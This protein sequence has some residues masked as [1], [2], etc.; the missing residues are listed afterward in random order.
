MYHW[1]IHVL[2]NLTTRAGFELGTGVLIN[3][4]S[5]EKA[6]EDMRAALEK[7]AMREGAPD[8]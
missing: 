7:I 3:V 5:P 1:H 4:V 6:A 2:P 8:S